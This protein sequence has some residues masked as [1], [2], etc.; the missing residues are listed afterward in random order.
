MAEQTN[1]VDGGFPSDLLVDLRPQH[2]RGLRER[3]E[4]GLRSAIQG[5][6]LP[7]GT[8]LPPSRVL[9]AE[10]EVSRSV[11]VAAYAN[12]TSDGYLEAR[13]GSGTRVRLDAPAGRPLAAL[14]RAAR[15]AGPR[16]GSSA[17]CPT[18]RCSRAASGCA[19]TAPRS[20]RCPDRRLT[21]PP[22]AGATALRVALS[23]Y[24][25]RVRGVDTDHRRML[26]CSGVTQGLA[27][28]CRAL[29][30]GGARRVAVED[31]C[32]GLHREAIAMTG[33]EPVPVP[34]DTDGLD[35]RA[36]ADHAPDAVLVAPAHSYPTGRHARRAAAAR[37]RRRGR[38][39]ATR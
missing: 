14:P 9:A 3:L 20:P 10:L 26:V 19:T 32:F 5:G 29:H 15:R 12:L 39:A 38:A 35:V 36:L 7:G 24:L 2:G 8:A 18:R 23:G 27:L 37:A 28:V 1:S 16:S 31:P 6:R 22:P 13:Q 11:V 30:R 34:V 25:G 33:L 17:G 4:H 21:Y